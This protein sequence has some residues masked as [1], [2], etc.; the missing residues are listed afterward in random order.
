MGKRIN[1]SKI[2]VGRRARAAYFAVLRRSES[3]VD[4]FGGAMQLRRVS[5]R[6]GMLLFFAPIA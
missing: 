3:L 1:R 6:A 4:V 5:L 2:G